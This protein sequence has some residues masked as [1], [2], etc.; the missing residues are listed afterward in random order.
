MTNSDLKAYQEY[1]TSKGRQE[2]CGI[3][4]AATELAI[5]EFVRKCTAQDSHSKLFRMNAMQRK[6]GV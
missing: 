5:V 1:F 6:G 2:A 3:M 4:S